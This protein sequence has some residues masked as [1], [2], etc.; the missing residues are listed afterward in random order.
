MYFG[1][2][3]G[4]LSVTGDVDCIAVLTQTLAIALAIS[5]SSS[6]SK[7]LI[8]PA[9]VGSIPLCDVAI[10]IVAKSDDERM[11][12]TTSNEQQSCKGRWAGDYKL[13]VTVKVLP[14]PGSLTRATEPRCDSAASFTMER[15]RPLPPLVRVRPSR[16]R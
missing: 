5:K 7:T 1:V 8:S 9:P 3:Q 13:R 12:I 15:P 2:I 4:L 16:T 10:R 11:S 6:V 14:W